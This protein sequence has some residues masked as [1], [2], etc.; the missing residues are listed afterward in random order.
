MLR[1]ACCRALHSSPVPYGDPMAC[2][3]GPLLASSRLQFRRSASSFARPI[4]GTPL[5]PSSS[6]VMCIVR[7]I[8][9]TTTRPHQTSFSLLPPSRAVECGFRMK[10]ARTFVGIRALWSQGTH[11]PSLMGPFTC[12]RVTACMRHCLGQVIA[13][14]W[15]RTLLQA[16]T[17]C[18]LLMC[19]FLNPWAFAGSLLRLRWRG[20]P[21]SPACLNPNSAWGL[22][23][24]LR[25]APAC[26]FPNP[27][28]GLVLPLRFAPACRN[29][30]PAWGLV[31]PPPRV[32]LWPR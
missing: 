12:Q 16:L 7:C 25:V 31:P 10:P 28:W 19:N 1:P 30:N 32:A 13:P 5:P 21:G 14:S 22:V 11:T 4:V 17:P 26:R 18:R 3:H 24:P 27:A 8:R 23:P 9:T 2:K 29:P 6:Y 15:P 20:G